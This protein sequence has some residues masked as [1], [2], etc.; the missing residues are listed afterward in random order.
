[1]IVADTNLMVYLLVRG[2]NTP[3]AERVYAL[4]PKWVA[5]ALWKSEFRN[6]LILYVRNRL[7]ELEE[8]A[9]YCLLAERLI[10]DSSIP[11]DSLKV[12]S[13]AAQSGCSAYDCEFVAL[14]QE[15]GV[16]LVTSDRKIAA[17]F[18]PAAILLR[19]FVRA[20]RP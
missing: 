1:M 12:L 13:L 10:E 16:P 5:P 4:D 7:M 8:A 17:R 2:Q 18:K 19:D 3:E 14:A 20:G 11:V 6:A 9:T 15:L